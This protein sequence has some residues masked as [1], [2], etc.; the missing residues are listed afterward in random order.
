MVALTRKVTILARGVPDR[1]A[2]DVTDAE[3]EHFDRCGWVK[4][5]GFVTEQLA[6]ELLETAQRIFAA[7]PDKP[8]PLPWQDYAGA[9]GTD[10]TEPIRSLVLSA[11]IGRA[12]WRL[13]VRRRT[14][15]VRY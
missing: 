7:R 8:G 14:V 2:R 15:G 9:G 12:A 10:G 4:L 3:A 11:D 13:G 5:D 6:S 1:V